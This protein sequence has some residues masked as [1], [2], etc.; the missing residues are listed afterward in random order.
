M[1]NEPPTTEVTGGLLT[2]LAYKQAKS[3][4]EFDPLPAK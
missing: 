2:W 1:D 3:L 4:F